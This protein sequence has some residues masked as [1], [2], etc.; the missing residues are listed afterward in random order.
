M[1]PSLALDVQEYRVSTFRGR[2]VVRFPKGERTEGI[3]QVRHSYAEAV[4]EKGYEG[5]EFGYD[6]QFDR[7]SVYFKVASRKGI[8]GGARI[9]EKD[10]DQQL[11]LED[12]RVEGTDFGLSVPRSTR[13]GE[14]T[15]FWFESHS[16]FCA[17][18]AGMVA[19]ARDRYERL[20]ATYDV[21]AG[22]RR[23]YEGVL[24]MRETNPRLR[25]VHDG[26]RRNGNDVRWGVMEVG[27]VGLGRVADSTHFNPAK[28]GT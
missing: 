19:F 2:E 22:M 16:D 12:A 1:E 13:R 18:I 15:T 20:Y 4:R 28:L 26:Y 27:P 21:E 8:T 7:N 25:V 9:V 5:F 10:A 17:L 23:L 6:R 14:F 11:P 24:T 3:E